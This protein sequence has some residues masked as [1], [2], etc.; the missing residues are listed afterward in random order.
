MLTRQIIT[1]RA[2]VRWGL[3]VVDITPPI[4]IYHRMFG[5]ATHDRATGIHRP[6]QA[7]VIAVSSLE[8]SKPGLIRGELDHCGFV[9]SQHAEL[10]RRVSLAADISPEQVIVGYSHSHAAGWYTPDRFEL[11]GG[12]LIPAYLTAIGDALETATRTAVAD[13][14]PA[15]ISYA[16]S[17]CAMA[18]HRDCWDDEAG[19]FVCGTNPGGPCDERVTVGR[20]TSPEGRVRAVLVHY[21]CHPTTLGWE[22]SLISP[23]FVGAMRETVTSVTGAPCVFWQGASGDLGPR[24]GFVGDTAVADRNG[25]M[26]GFAALSALEALG[27]AGTE[28]RYAGPVVSGAT[29]GAWKHQPLEPDHRPQRRGFGG[30]RGTVALPLR[31]RGEPAELERERVAWEARAEEARRQVDQKLAR[32]CHAQAERARRWIGRIAGL[33]PGDICH[34]SASVHVVGESLWITSGGEPYQWLAAELRRRFPEYTVLYS[35]LV[36]G[37]QMGYLLPRS[38]YGRGLYQEEP[39]PLASGC[40]ELLFDALVRRTEEV[41]AGRTAPA[42]W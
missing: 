7:D 10:I 39:S 30:R 16:N 27:P 8:Q 33:P 41:L 32:D 28:F 12:D 1:P 20:V 23:D 2:N 42:D 21:A 31:P 26:L 19:I 15:E 34:L 17:R 22:N 3:G 29:L 6:L 11:P 4:G 18:A 35:P 5:A 37:I 13:L 14:A 36:D 38:E 9:S 25:R 24:D 40:L